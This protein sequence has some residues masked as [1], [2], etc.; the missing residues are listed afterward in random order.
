[1]KTQIALIA[2]LLI[3][4]PV[5]ANQPMD[6]S[7]LDLD[8][9]VNEGTLFVSSQT[10]TANGSLGMSRKVLLAIRVSKNPTA[11]GFLKCLNKDAPDTIT[12]EVLDDKTLKVLGVAKRMFGKISEG[13]NG[14]F[15]ESNT[16]GCVADVK[17]LELKNGVI[18]LVDNYGA[19][20]SLNIENVATVAMPAR[21]TF[22][23]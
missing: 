23:R 1:M 2:S 20:T 15:R 18:T 22:K 7:P 13:S 4:T 6:V 19:P 21:V 14:M 9:S 12:I 11:Q 8:V 5:L 10:F 17:T 3:A 16:N